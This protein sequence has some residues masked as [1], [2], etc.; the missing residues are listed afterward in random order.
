MSEIGQIVYQKIFQ[1]KRTIADRL[2]NCMSSMP[3][4]GGDYSR[5]ST[6]LKKFYFNIDFFQ[7]GFSF[8]AVGRLKAERRRCPKTLF[9]PDRK[10]V[11]AIVAN[12]CGRRLSTSV[13]AK[14]GL[15]VSKNVSNQKWLTVCDHIFFRPKK[16]RM[17]KMECINHIIFLNWGKNSIEA[18]ASSKKISTGRWERGLGFLWCHFKIWPFK[19]TISFGLLIFSFNLMKFTGTLHHI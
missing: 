6:R 15:T 18:W 16:T 9:S 5:Q 1:S 17:V 19:S 2:W 13:V 7:N 3:W 11:V 14:I 12:V 8:G 10:D 4:F